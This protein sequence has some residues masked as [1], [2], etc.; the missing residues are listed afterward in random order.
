MAGF[1]KYGDMWKDE[2]GRCFCK[3]RRA[4]CDECCQ[5]F[6]LTNEYIEV[7]AGL[8]AKKSPVDECLENIEMLNKGIQFLEEQDGNNPA[9]REN[10]EYHYE[11]L[12][13]QKAEY[14]KLTGQNHEQIGN[15]AKSELEECSEFIKLHED[16][17]EFFSTN[18][19]GE[20]DD[21]QL[22]ENFKLLALRKR[23]FMKLGGKLVCAVCNIDKPELMKCTA[24]GI[25]VYC[26]RVSR[27]V[28]FSNC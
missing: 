21:E 19:G 28:C 15:S 24:C 17:I 2:V 6:T 12:A 27:F 18:G 5:D 22:L 3:H 26:S 16:S 13:I 25:V 4:E 11:Q 8:R 7:D 20:L 9:F 1:T 23:Q 14:K 10:L